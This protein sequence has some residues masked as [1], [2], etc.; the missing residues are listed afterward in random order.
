MKLT[1]VMSNQS[2]N[3]ETSQVCS[4][5]LPPAQYINNYTDENIKRGRAP[6]PP[7]PINDSYSMFGNTFNADD[8]I[9]RPLEAQVSKSFTY[10]TFI[11]IVVKG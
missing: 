9:I 5:P 6:K 8:T 1:F 7:P 4:L 11:L 2:Q 10:T 3:N